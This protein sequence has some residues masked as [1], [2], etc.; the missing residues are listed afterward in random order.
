MT[1]AKILIVED[2]GIIAKS[3]KVVLEEFGYEISSITSSGEEAIKKVKKDKPDLVL[4]DIML[5]GDINGIEAAKKIKSDFN[6]PVI[7]LTAYTDKQILERAKI[8]EPFGY[9]VKPFENRELCSTIE[10]ALYKNQMEKKIDRLNRV[11]RAIRNVNKLITREKDRNILLQKA[12]AHLIETQGYFSAWVALLDETNKL[13]TTAEAGLGKDFLPMVSLLKH[14][15]LPDCITKALVKTELVVI[16]DAS[17]ICRECPISEKYCSKGALTI[18]L[19]SNN[20]IYGV[21]SVSID[22]SLFPLDEEL[23]LFTEVTEDIAFALRNIELEEGQKQA[24]EALRESE[25]RYRTLT[26]KTIAGIYLVQDGLFKYV[27]PTFCKIHGYTKDELVDKFGPLDL[28]VEEE[29]EFLKDKIQ[30]RLSGERESDQFSIRIRRK[31]GEI[32]FLEV[33]SSYALYAGKPAVLGTCIDVTETRKAN[34]AIKKSREELRALTAY[35]QNIREEERIRISREIHDELGHLLTGI[36]ID[37]S[38]LKK[39]LDNIVKPTDPIQAKIDSLLGLTDSVIATTREL[40]LSLRPGILDD[41]GIVAAIN[42]E[43]KRFQ[44]KTGIICTFQSDMAE[45]AI[46]EDYTTALFRICQECLT[47]IA[48]YAH[49]TEMKITLLGKEGNLVLEIEDNGKGIKTEQIRSPLSLGILGMRER[50]V[51]L[52]G[53][54]SIRGAPGKGT[55][56]KVEVPMR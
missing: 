10:I 44:E 19:Q 13:I 55:K 40:S 33:F 41:L 45:I 21:L 36:K 35:L 25:E 2:E 37:I 30:Q 46:P 12:C 15:K 5:K 18:R 50:V 26:E 23:S 51:G 42:W 20:K 53:T 52:R 38:W 54:F 49:A 31:D 9:I 11:L 27:N 39:K 6:I 1:E 28:V 8:T 34:E 43:I 32:R 14:G 24:E 47:N 56:V 17:S 29:K 3:L 22:L 7:Y 16:K 4:M 48:R